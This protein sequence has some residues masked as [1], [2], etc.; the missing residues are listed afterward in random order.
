MKLLFLL[1]LI[2]GAFLFPVLGQDPTK[3]A[4]FIEAERLSSDAERYYNLGKYDEALKLA[5]KE[6]SLREK[7]ADTQNLAIINFNIGG[8]YR[9]KKDYVKS[10]K[11]F[12]TAITYY[13]QAFGGNHEKVL[14]ALN[15]LFRVLILKDEKTRAVEV[16]KT[17]NGIAENL[18][19]KESSQVADYYLAQAQVYKRMNRIEDA[20]NA[21]QQAILVND[22]LQK[23][24]LADERAEENEYMCFLINNPSINFDKKWDAFNEK[25]REIRGEKFLQGNF[26]NGKAIKLGRPELPARTSIPFGGITIIVRV[27]IGENGEV[28]QA[29]AVCN[30]YQ[31]LAYASIKAAFQSKFTPTLADGKAIKVRGLIKYSFKN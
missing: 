21:Y 28:E 27:T 10:I 12:E 13:Q 8:I 1:F 7:L 31:V 14:N 17:A 16:L 18:Y 30:E 4:E 11:Y 9:E 15:Q 24:E 20:D 3:T 26:V 19:G 2:I 6:L 29:T 22:K 5:L 23:T 25:R